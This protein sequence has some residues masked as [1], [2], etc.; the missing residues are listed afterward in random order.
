VVDAD[1]EQTE[2]LNSEKKKEKEFDIKKE[3]KSSGR[4]ANNIKIQ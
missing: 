4:G 1:D 3:E 2:V